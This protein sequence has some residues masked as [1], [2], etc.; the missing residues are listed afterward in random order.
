MATETVNFEDFKR[1]LLSVVQAESDHLH[2]QIEN[3]CD[4]LEDIEA[5]VMGHDFSLIE[6]YGWTKRQFGIA[7]KEPTT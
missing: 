6:I 1:T 3:H 7:D 2:T 5:Y 4:D